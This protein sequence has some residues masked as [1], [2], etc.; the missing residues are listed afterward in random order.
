[1][2]QRCII[3]TSPETYDGC[4]NFATDAW[5]SPNGRAFVALTV[6]F[7]EEGTAVSTL[8]DIVE[9]AQSHSGV[10]LARVFARV[11]DNYKLSQKVSII[12]SAEGFPETCGTRSW[13]LPVTMQ[14]RTTQ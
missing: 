2:T 11:L 10:S 1:M 14:V 3:L 6:H 9:L 4:L 8:L 12:L 5:T 7:E 13:Q